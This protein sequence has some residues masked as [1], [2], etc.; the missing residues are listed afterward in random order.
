MPLL[1][2]GLTLA[3]CASRSRATRVG[4]AVVLPR[5]LHCSLD[6]VERD[7]AVVDP[8]DV[9]GTVEVWGVGEDRA[10][11]E[12]ELQLRACA[13]GADAVIELHQRRDADGHATW[14]GRA[15]VWTSHAG[16]PPPPPPEPSMPP[17]SAVVEPPAEVAPVATVDE[18]PPAQEPS[19]AK[20]KRKSKRKRRRRR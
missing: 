5:S 15:V 13:L 11:L 7:Q 19:R 8:H 4:E 6:F 10:A 20:N 12:R 3:A 2:L 1:V 16:G 9:V 18:E 17:P 14:L